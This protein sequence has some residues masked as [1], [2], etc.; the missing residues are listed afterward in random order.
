MGIKIIMDC[1]H[2]YQETFYV[3]TENFLM[4]CKRDLESVRTWIENHRQKIFPGPAESCMMHQNWHQR[5]KILHLARNER[6][7]DFYYW[8][9]K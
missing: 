7:Y 5:H 9:K 8:N 4:T 1:F 2:I 3:V 6:V